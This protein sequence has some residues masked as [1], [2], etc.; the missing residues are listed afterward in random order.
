MP[1]HNTTIC[2]EFGLADV[3]GCLGC[4]YDDPDFGCLA[5][6]VQTCKEVRNEN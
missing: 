1:D 3:F 4:P 6:F 5:P 2:E